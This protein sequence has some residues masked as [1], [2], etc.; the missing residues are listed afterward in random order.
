LS[1][2]ALGNSLGINLTTIGNNNAPPGNKK[3]ARLG[4]DLKISNS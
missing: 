3:I 1:S 4:M 2:K